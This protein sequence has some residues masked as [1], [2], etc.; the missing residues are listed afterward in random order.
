MYL[1]T[2]VVHLLKNAASHNTFVTENSREQKFLNEFF[3]ICHASKHVSPSGN[4]NTSTSQ[5]I[6]KHIQIIQ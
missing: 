6:Y 5:S 3:F 2:F 4:N 1:K